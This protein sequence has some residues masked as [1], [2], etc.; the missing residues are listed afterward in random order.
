MLS[1]ANQKQKILIFSMIIN[2]ATSLY[3]PPSLC[4]KQ[5]CNCFLGIS[6]RI[7]GRNAVTLVCD[8]A[9]FLRFSYEARY[10]VA[11]R[12]V[13]LHFRTVRKNNTD[14]SHPLL[15]AFNPL[16]ALNTLPILVL[17]IEEHL[18]CIKVTL[19]ILLFFINCNTFCLLFS[20]YCKK[21]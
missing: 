19:I 1:M 17:H 14:G 8:M 9:L 12:K 20:Q 2:I 21:F 6:H 16:H 11:C 7:L 3:R 18:L 4:H 10:V 15:E 13:C 5:L